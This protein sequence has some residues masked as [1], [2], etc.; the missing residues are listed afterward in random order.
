MPLLRMLEIEL[1]L[2]EE[3]VL[4]LRPA[5]PMLCWRERGLAVFSAAS[6]AELEK[7]GAP[8]PYDAEGGKGAA[9]DEKTG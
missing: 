4:G 8:A 2:P 5:P 1:M 6:D 7:Q 3:A 9:D